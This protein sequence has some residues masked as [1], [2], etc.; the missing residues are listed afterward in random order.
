MSHFQQAILKIGDFLIVFAVV[1]AVVIVTVALF[2]GDPFIETIQFALILTVAAIPVALPT[3][4]SVTLAVG[5]RLLSK[6]QAV[7]SRL[8]AIEELA[9]M[10][11][12]CSDKTGTLTQNKLAARRRVRRGWEPAPMT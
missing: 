10:D 9:G 12:L 4:L 1:L 5:A 2:R 7:V 3:V 11:T 8:A 6:S